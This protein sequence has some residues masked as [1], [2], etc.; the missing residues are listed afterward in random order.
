MRMV[1]Q[2][3]VGCGA[4]DIR[5]PREAAPGTSPSPAHAGTKARAE[6]DVPQV[7]QEL[8]RTLAGAVRAVGSVGAGGSRQL[9]TSA[10]RWDRCQGVQTGY[11]GVLCLWAVVLESVYVPECSCGLGPRQPGKED[12]YVFPSAGRATP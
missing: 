2:Q 3:S 7:G 5:P 11:L 4:D 8:P 12:L 9:G 10:M 6:A 1:P